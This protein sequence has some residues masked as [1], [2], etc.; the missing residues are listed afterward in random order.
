MTR[1]ETGAVTRI[2]FR[3]E[4]GESDRDELEE[5]LYEAVYGE[6]HAIAANLMRRE[7]VA[8]TLQSTALVHEA[9]LKLAD[10][11]VTTWQ[12]R[13]HFFGVASRAM[14]Q[15]LID[16]A[17]RF[18]ATKRG[19]DLQRVTLEDEIIAD[20][21]LPAD[22]LDLDAALEKLTAVDER[23]ARGVEMR[24]FGGLLSREVAHVLGVSKRTVDE[25]WKVA[26]MFLARELGAGGEA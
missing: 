9:F 20:S 2:L 14:R 5:R 25:D 19:G 10:Q 3:I 24:V 12:S 17:R 26:K 8:H 11:T 13:A 4:E 16:H 21:D 7:R 18:N 1:P 23:M 6:L 15:V 22:L